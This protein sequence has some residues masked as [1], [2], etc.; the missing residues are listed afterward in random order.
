MLALTLTFCSTLPICSA[1]PMKRWRKTDRATGSSTA[2]LM[3]CARGGLTSITRLSPARRAVELGPTS[4]V[5]VLST[6]RAGP[7]ITVP[8]AMEEKRYT[9]VSDHPRELKY[10]D[11]TEEGFGVTAGLSDE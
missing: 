10:T 11:F 6:T 1:T 2:V 9:G 3:L 8:A 4:R 7:W 5:C